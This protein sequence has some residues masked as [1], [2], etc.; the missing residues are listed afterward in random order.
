MSGSAS[1]EGETSE[2]RIGDCLIDAR[3]GLVVR[4]GNTFSLNPRTFAVLMELVNA[5]GD[6]VSGSELLERVWP[7]NHVG[8]NTVY[9]AISEIRESLGD[10]PSSPRYI[11]TVPRKGYRLIVGLD[12]H[13]V[14][15]KPPRTRR[16]IVPGAVAL[17]IALILAGA[18]PFI[19]SRDQPRQ[20]SVAILKFNNIDGHP[21]NDYLALGVAQSF[22]QN[23]S[24]LPNLRVASSSQTYISTSSDQSLS[25]IAKEFGVGHVLTGSIQRSD[26]AVRIS[27]QL[28][29]TSDGTSLFS[30]QMDHE[31]SDIL[32]LQDRVA[33]SVVEAL[34]IH[35]DDVQR[36]Q[37][38]DW[39]TTSAAA[40]RAYLKAEHLYHYES[41]EQ[42]LSLAIE[43]YLQALES[44]PEFSLARHALLNALSWTSMRITHDQ[45]DRIRNRAAGIYR[46]GILNNPTSEHTASMSLFMRKLAGIGLRSVEAECRK[47]ISSGTATYQT[48]VEYGRILM[49]AR[50]FTE[51]MQ[52]IDKAAAQADEIHKF[53]LE[54]L[55]NPG[56]RGLGRA[57]EGIS[58]LENALESNSRDL[59][60]IAGLIL[61]HVDIGNVE[62][63]EHYLKMLHETDVSGVWSYGLDL[64]YHT[65]T[66]QLGLEDLENGE[67]LKQG[68]DHNFGNGVAFLILG[69]VP[70]GLHYWG[71]LNRRA[72]EAL[73]YW[74]PSYEIYFPDHVSTDQRYQEFLDEM[75]VGL[76][77]Q[78]SLL[79]HVETLAQNT[80]IHLSDHTRAT[81]NL[82]ARMAS[83]SPLIADE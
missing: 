77:W 21:D 76:E 66:G 82:R 78:E 31:L 51:G 2:I 47:M 64:I 28:L 40:Y 79:R 13:N 43:H 25:D 83:R 80:G 57:R 74:L 35:L 65:A 58:I 18:Y 48:Y 37:M 1:I 8:G 17:A 61:M 39:G 7:A 15:P 50:L 12:K 9:K 81:V 14:A 41:S 5:E 38:L 72:I 36:Q 3:S 62:Q 26:E 19:A 71:R 46:A 33:S 56:R 60:N 45:L 70:S 73:Y 52:Y 6:L 68:D 49:G 20:P 29:R 44:D 55:K 34:K 63:A 42:D 54:Q 53:S 23:L 11:E 75:G 4:G 69:D 32:M 10:N 22:V 30:E 59:A 27:I 16:L 24:R 67:V